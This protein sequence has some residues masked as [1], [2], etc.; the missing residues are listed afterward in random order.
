MKLMSSHN[1]IAKD[2]IDAWCDDYAALCEKHGLYLVIDEDAWL[3][4]EGEPLDSQE[5][6]ENMREML[7][8]L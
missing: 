3:Q 4:E 7:H 1:N 5:A 6:G 8:S 2:K